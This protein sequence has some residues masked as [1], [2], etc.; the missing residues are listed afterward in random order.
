V[1]GGVTNIRGLSNTLT[2]LEALNL[3]GGGYK[4]LARTAAAAILSSCHSNVDYPYT[5]QQVKDAVVSMFNT[6]T[7]VLGGVTYTT[8]EGLKNELDRANNLGCPLSR[9]NF[10]SSSV[11]DE[12]AQTAVISKLKVSAFPNPYT[13][14]VR[15]VIESPV[16]GEATLQV[17]NALGQK[18]AVVY[19]GR[20]NANSSQIFEYRIPTPAPQAVI[21]TLTIGSERIVGKLMRANKQ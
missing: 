12:T 4:A 14:V 9:Q 18:I 16:S 8:V 19:K 21:Y 3:N 20:I 5:T 17:S 6:G 13:D 10:Q 7:A 2:L 11:L 1:F 15:F